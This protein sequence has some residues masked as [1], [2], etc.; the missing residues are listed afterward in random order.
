MADSVEIRFVDESD[1]RKE[2][3]WYF[4]SENSQWEIC[5]TISSDSN[6]SLA[7]IS[8]FSEEIESKTGSDSGHISSHDG[9]K[10][11]TDSDYVGEP[12]T[13]AG[14]RKGKK[15]TNKKKKKRKRVLWWQTGEECSR[16]K[17]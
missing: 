17:K 3:I 1:F 11:D 13:S 16:C 15:S 4:W 6:D 14:S 5:S 7:G 8:D 2:G 10:S 9:S 12:S